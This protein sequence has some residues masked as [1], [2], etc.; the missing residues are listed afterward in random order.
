M[1]RSKGGP[2]GHS[3][4]QTSPHELFCV[5]G[6]SGFTDIV[7]NDEVVMKRDGVRGRH[8]DRGV[9]RGGCYCRWMT[10]ASCLLE[11]GFHDQ[12]TDTLSLGRSNFCKFETEGRTIYPPDQGFIDAHRP[13]LILQEQG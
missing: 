8:L 5:T 2:I 3:L 9:E 1:K 10:W 12:G 6:D 4:H 13:F 11:L 7:R